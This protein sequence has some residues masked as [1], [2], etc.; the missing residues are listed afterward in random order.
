MQMACRLSAFIVPFFWLKFDNRTRLGDEEYFS[1]IKAKI[2]MVM[3]L[4]TFMGR[5]GGLHDDADD[6]YSIFCRSRLLVARG[7][8]ALGAKI[9]NCTLIDVP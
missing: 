8:T 7:S 4:E 1:M 9:L 2:F 5:S 6:F 3:L